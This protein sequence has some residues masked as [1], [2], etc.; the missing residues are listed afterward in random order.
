[1][2]REITR[3]ETKKALFDTLEEMLADEWSRGQCGLH[4]SSGEAFLALLGE[5][6]RRK[7]GG[8]RQYA[9][10]DFSHLEFPDAEWE[11]S[12]G[13]VAAEQIEEVADLLGEA[14]PK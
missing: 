12:R 4:G 7:A 14:L 13:E 6:L 10:E 8:W 9:A 1:M 3:E 11:R 2:T 5:K